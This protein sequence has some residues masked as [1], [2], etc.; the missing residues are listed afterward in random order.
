MWNSTKAV[1]NTVKN[2]KNMKKILYISML[3][4]VLT[5]GFTACEYDDSDVKSDIEDLESRVEALEALVDEIEEDVAALQTLVSAAQSGDWITDVTEFSE[6]GVTGWY[7]TFNS[8]GTITITNGTD[9]TDGYT[10]T[11]GV[12]LVNG[13]YYW[14]IDGSIVYDDDGD[15]VS[16]SPT[17]GNATGSPKL[18]IGDDGCWYYSIDG[19]STWTY[20]AEGDWGQDVDSSSGSS[21]F[22]KVET[23]GSYAYFYL[24]DGSIVTVAIGGYFYITLSSE[25]VT[26]A[27]GSSVSVTYTV[28]G[29]GDDTVVK[30]YA[31]DDYTATVTAS[32]TSEGSITITAP[33]SSAPTTSVWVFLSDGDQRLVTYYIDVN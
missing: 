13:V 5:L 29:A 25:S 27:A 28:T 11:V 3:T 7:I 21:V 2:G 17:D 9:G 32:S 23:D 1:G 19:G 20:L 24:A 4:L 22:S 26:V 8:Y 6:D 33:S 30:T 12:T 18:K 14:T 16:V 31:Q 15:P 10:P